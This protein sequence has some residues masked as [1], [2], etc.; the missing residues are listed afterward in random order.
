MLRRTQ[1]ETFEPR[2][3][4][5]AQPVGDFFID[6]ALIPRQQIEYAELAPTLADVHDLTGVSY[7]RDTYGFTGSGQTVAI[8]DTG[9]AYDHP[10]LGGGYGENFRVVGG[11]DYAESDANPYDDG[12]AG[13]HGTHVAGIVASDDSTNPG[14]AT[15]ADLVALRVIND[16]GA[17]T[18]SSVE[19]ALNWVHRNR[20]AFANQIT[21]VNLSLGTNWNSDSIP[22]WAMLEDE[23]SQLEADGIFVSVA[24]GNAFQYFYSTGLSYPAASPFVVPVASH[25][26]D[27][28]MSS[29]SQ[30]NDRVIA[31]PGEMINSTIPSHKSDSSDPSDQFMS[32]SGTSMAAPYM[33]GASVIVREAMEFAGYQNITQDDIYDH[34][35]NTADL[36]FDPVTDANYHRLNLQQALDSLMPDDDY[37]SSSATAYALGTLDG[38]TTISGS[39]G[40]LDDRDFFTFTAAHTGQVNLSATSTH[41]MVN[42]WQLVD[43]QG[44]MQDGVFSFAV[45]NGQT[46][47]VSLGTSAGLG[48][49]EISVEPD[50]VFPV[51]LG[52][53]DFHRLSD[54][55]LDESQWYQFAATR[56]GLLTAEAL[57]AHSDGDV[58]LQLYDNDGQLLS[59]SSTATDNE[60]IDV[61]VTQ[62][63]VFLLHVE[64]LNSDVDLR[65]TNLVETNGAEIVVNGTTGDD[66]FTLTVGANHDVSVNGVDYSFASAEFTNIR[67][68]GS[69]GNDGVVLDGSLSDINVT[70]NGI[71]SVINLPELAYQLDQQLGLTFTGDYYE[72]W[73]G[74]GE[75]WMQSS[76]GVW[77]FVTPDGTLYRWNGSNDLAQSEV[78]ANLNAAYHAD[79]SKLHDA[80]QVDVG[81]MRDLV[82]TPGTQGIVPE[83]QVTTPRTQVTTP[84]AQV[85]T[86]KA[87]VITPRT[88]VIT[89]RTQVTTPEVLVM[90]P[91]VVVTI[92]EAQVMVPIHHSPKKPTTW[93][94]NTD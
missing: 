39:I 27:G 15:E 32:A 80:P 8:I 69:E 52:T 43:G 3:V 10:A 31:A 76:D 73:G 51:D 35:R 34:L 46:Y 44:T 41:S 92:P 26:N 55:S 11:Y 5:S 28:T 18:F 53:V 90:T 30:R 60:R 20:N 74:S 85:T 9:I 81:S 88:Q 2:L 91:E 61:A 42:D 16:H 7:V 63:D 83:A 38:E 56:T 84:K 65:I 93:I 33:A 4:L 25:G 72:D 71:E 17:G 87:Q 54:Q 75:K 23:F 89:P 36:F 82:M 24:A 78:V 58:E 79:A 22:A 57:F 77:M 40:R 37:G 47:T 48:H 62:G 94:N 64:G 14:V 6:D 19:R 68:E 59:S 50:Q 49:Y 66:E 29:F 1:F 67:F 12:P 13:F 86:P 45:T 70:T 21:T